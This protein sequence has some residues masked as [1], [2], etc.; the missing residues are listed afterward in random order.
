MSDEN[1]AAP[2]VVVGELSA[3][4][5]Y[6]PISI[7]AKTIT[8]APP[9]VDGLIKDARILADMIAMSEKI[10]WGQDS[11]ML[12]RLADALAAMQAKVG[13]L[14]EHERSANA[15]ADELAAALGTEINIRKAAQSR[16]AALTE[17]LEKIKNRR[18]GWAA[19]IARAALAQGGENE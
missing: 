16:I 2:P 12:R 1:K 3:Y 18:P 4:S 9:V 5:P 11:D 19:E 17:A 14:E 13:E 10:A 15:V 6:T 8:A 7:S